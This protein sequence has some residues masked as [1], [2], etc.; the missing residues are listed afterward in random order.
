MQG[1]RSIIW[2][3]LLALTLAGCVQTGGMAPVAPVATPPQPAAGGPLSAR[4][5]ADNFIAVVDRVEPVAERICRQQTA[6]R[7]N[8]DLQIAI[9]RRFDQPPNA[10]QTLDEAGRPVIGFT[11]ALIADARN[12]DEVAF[13]LGHEAAHHI[14]GH[15]SRQQETAMR[16]AVLGAVLGQIAGADAATLDELQRMGATVGARSYSKGYELEADALGAEIAW[17]SGFDP[18]LGAGFFAR[19]PDPGDQF[20]GSHPPNSQRQAQVAAVV[21]RLRA[22]GVAPGAGL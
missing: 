3:A 19:L 16:G 5:A 8:C 18:V 15:I 1:S 20:L 17:A 21:A 13:V 11:L 2:G 4:A 6:G 7:A 12:A 22:A 10:F 14:L 9:D